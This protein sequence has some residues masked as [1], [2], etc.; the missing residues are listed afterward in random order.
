MK[1]IIDSIR[2]YLFEQFNEHMTIELFDL[3][4]DIHKKFEF[5]DQT[6]YSLDEWLKIFEKR[7]T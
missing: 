1:M 2:S 4:D 5:V 6:E 7:L 3:C